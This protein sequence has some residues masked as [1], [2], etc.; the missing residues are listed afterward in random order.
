VTIEVRNAGPAIDAADM[1]RLMQP[2]ERG[3][4]HRP[5]AGSGLGLAIVQRIARQHGGSLR[6]EPTSAPGG[7]LALIEVAA[8]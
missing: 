4:V 8:A 3:Q 5:S 7:T 6:L 1:Q 2:F